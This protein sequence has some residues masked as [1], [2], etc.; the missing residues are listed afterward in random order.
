MKC[1]RCDLVCYALCVEK[2][3]GGACVASYALGRPNIHGDTIAV[4]LVT[5]LE[6][7]VGLALTHS[8]CYRLFVEQT[9]F[10]TH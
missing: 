6:L 9:T 3:R 1:A 5:V 2:I 8:A 4:V 10:A 7:V